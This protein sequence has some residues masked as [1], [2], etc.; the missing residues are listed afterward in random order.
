MIPLA[1]VPKNEWAPYKEPYMKEKEQSLVLVAQM[2][3]Q[4]TGWSRTEIV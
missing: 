3:M 4:R 2:S 1:L